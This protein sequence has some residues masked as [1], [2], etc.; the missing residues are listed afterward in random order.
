M[1]DKAVIEETEDGEIVISWY[2]D[3]HFV[4]CLSGPYPTRGEAE[5]DLPLCQQQAETWS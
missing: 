3:G 4:E 2:R 1:F 5:V